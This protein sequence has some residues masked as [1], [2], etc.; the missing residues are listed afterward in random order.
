M[1]FN[2]IELCRA[3]TETKLSREPVVQ[4]NQV[5][6]QDGEPALTAG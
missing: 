6:K 1:L 3:A 5:I 4:R 2:L